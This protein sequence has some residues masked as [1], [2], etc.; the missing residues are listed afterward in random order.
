M[1]CKQDPLRYCPNNPVSRAQMVTLLRRG[2]DARPEPASFT[3]TEGPR[4][5]DTL[6]AASQART[7][8]VRLDGTVTCWGGEEGLPEHLSASGL[9]DIAALSTGQD[10]IGGLHTCVV[11]EDGTVSCWGPGHEGQLGLGNTETHHLPVAVP[12]IT[13]A[14]AVAV[15]SA[16][17]CVAHR[18]GGV[19]CWGR[20]WYGQLGVHIE[21]SSRSN[22]RASSRTG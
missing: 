19:S 7:C 13:D 8:A 22:A 15:G 4:S 17:T 20:S 10:P 21:E 9:S 18:G 1:G 3:I 11:H 12:G 5:G 2:L 6:L 16:F 14:V